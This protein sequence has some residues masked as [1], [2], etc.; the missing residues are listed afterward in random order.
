MVYPIS[1]FNSM[2]FKEY[3]WLRKVVS[4]IENEFLRPSL[5]FNYSRERNEEM[6]EEFVKYKNFHVESPMKH[7]PQQR[8]PSPFFDEGGEVIL[9]H[10]EH[11]EESPQKQRELN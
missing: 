10:E 1:P 5:I 4:T 9:E 6:Y 11:E 2:N 7:D 3:H 8:D